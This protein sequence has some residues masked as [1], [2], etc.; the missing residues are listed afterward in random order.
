ME[1][2]VDD[3]SKAFV[4]VDGQKLYSLYDLYVWLNFCSDDSFRYHVNDNE[5]H[6]YYWIKDALNFKELAEI[7]K[8]VK[9]R[10]KMKNIIALFIEEEGRFKMNKDE[11]LIYF[12]KEYI[13]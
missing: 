3:E 10:E 4:T 12:V 1:Y 6:F 13:K 7:I 11:A 8:N 2:M 5:N 9:D